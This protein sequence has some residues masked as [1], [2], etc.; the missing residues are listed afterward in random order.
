MRTLTPQQKKELKKWFDKNYDGG[1]KFE[2]A[3]KIDHET[4]QRIEDMNPTEIHYHNVNN[5]L[6]S[7]V[8]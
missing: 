1:Y 4:Y 2:M 8:K 6:E 5:Y 3:D 7:L